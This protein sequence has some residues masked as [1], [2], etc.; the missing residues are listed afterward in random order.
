M[1]APAV[2]RLAEGVYR[3]EDERGP[4]IVYVAGAGDD[5]WACAGGRVYRGRPDGRP[6]GRRRARPE[7]KESLTAP[8]PATVLRVLVEP[9]SAVSRGDTLIVLEAMKM[10]LPIRASGDGVVSAVLCREGELVQPDAVLVEL[11]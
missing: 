7:G 6:A 10:E 1:G 2:T 5:V 11:E 3:V 4:V 9:G 8:M